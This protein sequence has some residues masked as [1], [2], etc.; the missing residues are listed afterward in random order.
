S[1]FHVPQLWSRELVERPTFWAVRA[2]RGWSIE[3]FAFAPIKTSKVTARQRCPENTIRIDISA[4]G[5]EAG[6][7]NLI[8]LTQCRLARIGSGLHSYDCAGI[9]HHGSPY[10]AVRGADGDGIN[11]H[12]DAFVL[13]GIDRLIGSNEGIALSVAVSV[14]DEWR[15]SLRLHLVARFF[16]HLAI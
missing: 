13:R 10:G 3:D 12:Q 15:P 6:R 4:A 14:N 7:W 5:P 16:K 11:I 9:S 2:R 8:Y 1:I